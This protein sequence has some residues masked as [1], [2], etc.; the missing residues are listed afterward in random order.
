MPK[1]KNNI[2]AFPVVFVENLYTDEVTISSPSTRCGI[3]G[4]EG[5]LMVA[6]AS[7]SS[8]KFFCDEHRVKVRVDD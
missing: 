1:W 8:T 7:W 4:K 2:V 5:V 6:D 3:C